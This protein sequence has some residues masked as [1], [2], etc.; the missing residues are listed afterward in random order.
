MLKAVFFCF[1]YAVLNVSGAALIK[2]KLK[3]RVLN[4]LS[5]WV[6]FLFDY[7]VILAFVIIFGSALV[8]FKA[9][10][11][12]NF[13][14]IIPVSVGI[15][16]ILTVIIG[17]FLFKDRMNYLSFIGFALIVTGIFLLSLN[18]VKHAQ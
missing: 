7:Q 4:Q 11:T 2:W 6:G 16:F 14:F 1:L 9:L 13:S 10:S 18:T 15:N 3:G 8:M 12:G 17:Y 5:D